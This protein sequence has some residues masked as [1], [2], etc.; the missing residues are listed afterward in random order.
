[1]RLVSLLLLA[2]VA[3]AAPLI[4]DARSWNLFDKVRV[5]GDS[6]SDDGSG[7]W[8]VSNFTWPADP[9]YFGHRFSNGKV[10]AEVLAGAL[11]LPIDDHAVGGA[12]VNDDVVQ[13]YTG[14]ASTIPSPSV[15]D[16]V[17]AFLKLPRGGSNDL[18]K[19][20]VIIYGG[21]NDAFFGLPNI[22]AA[23][24]VASVQVAVKRL[25][26]RGATHFLLPTLPP[27]GANYPFSTLVPSYSRPLAKFS[28]DHRAALLALA[29]SDPSIVVT[30][31]FPLFQSI[32]KNPASYGFDAAVLNRSCLR[33][34]Y[35]EVAG[36]VT[37][38]ENP[39]EYVWWDEYHPTKV[40][41]R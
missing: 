28:A 4:L 12:T 19:S 24:V 34:V 40:A 20:L 35:M 36:S 16:Q 17:A 11:R 8:T 39:R 22:T 26:A 6:L 18:T 31:L 23:E 25:K 33:G 14:P 1:M 7:A 10:Y 9:H 5:F 41:S 30:D 32:Y 37:V 15:L 2:A 13:G 29:E 27:L 38:C 21:A 3:Q